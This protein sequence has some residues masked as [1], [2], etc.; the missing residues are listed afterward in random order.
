MRRNDGGKRNHVVM[1]VDIVTG[2]IRRWRSMALAA[3]ECGLSVITI[4]RAVKEVKASH[5]YVW[6]NPGD[7]H[8]ATA[9][10]E[11]MRKNGIQPRQRGRPPRK[12]GMV[13]LQIDS[14]TRIKVKPEEATPEFAIR[15]LKRLNRK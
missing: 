6:C 7:E 13:W 14:H 10:A 3:S 1:S 2:E 12:D 15:Y 5:G 4:A 8:R 9:L 11:Y